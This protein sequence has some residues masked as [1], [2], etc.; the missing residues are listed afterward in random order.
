M[1]AVDAGVRIAFQPFLRFYPIQFPP[2][3]TCG[4]DM[5]STLLEILPVY[6]SL[7]IVRRVSY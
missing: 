1:I 4:V 2:E 3:L 6:Y 7:Y 5:V